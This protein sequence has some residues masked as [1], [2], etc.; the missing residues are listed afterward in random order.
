MK[1][2]INAF[3]PFKNYNARK[4]SP[5]HG[6]GGVENEWIALLD[7]KKLTMHPPPSLHVIIGHRQ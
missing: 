5:R 2:N 4:S 1:G 7:C 3:M 6:E